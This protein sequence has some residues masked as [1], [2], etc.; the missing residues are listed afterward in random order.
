[1][2]EWRERR[3]RPG[4]HAPAVASRRTE[5][6]QTKTPDCCAGGVYASYNATPLCAVEACACLVFF[7]MCFHEADACRED[8]GE[9]EKQ[10]ADRRPE[11]FRNHSGRHAYGSTECE[12]DQPLVEL[13]PLQC[14]EP[15]IDNHG[16][17]NLETRNQRAKEAPNQTGIRAVAAVSVRGLIRI[18]TQL[19]ALA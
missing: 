15:C 16:A 18:S 19:V 1:M 10:A 13:D 7:L 9:C 2:Q 3:R 5:S 17:P 14:G 6:S 8:C 4:L 11:C 12:P